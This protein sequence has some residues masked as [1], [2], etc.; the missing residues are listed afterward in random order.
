MFLSLKNDNYKVVYFLNTRCACTSIRS[1]ICPR[2]PRASKNCC[3]EEFKE[4]F[5]FSFVRNPF[6]RL[7]SLYTWPNL[8]LRCWRDLRFPYSMTLDILPPF[9]EF[10]KIVCS[11]SDDVNIHIISQ[12]V[13]IPY[14][15]LDFIGRFE[16][17]TE[18]WAM[19]QQRF[20]LAD[21]PWKKRSERNE[22]R[23]YYTDELC[24]M[25]AQRYA[26]DFELFRYPVH[27]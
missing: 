20:G 23:S 22:W 7:V 14:E 15:H 9:E 13:L 18:D 12:S 25:V 21:L 10:A 19:L 1:V 2:L 16:T 11:I 4:Y 26:R 8:L 5:W 3:R 27:K 17:I 6:D 24:E